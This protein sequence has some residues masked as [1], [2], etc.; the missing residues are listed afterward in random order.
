MIFS[1]KPITEH[2]VCVLD[3]SNSNQQ[4]IRNQLAAYKARWNESLATNLTIVT[5]FD[6]APIGAVVIAPGYIKPSLHHTIHQVTS[7]NQMTHYDLR[8]AIIS[9]LI[10]YEYT[11]NTDTALSWLDSLPTIF[12]ADFETSSK[13]DKEEKQ[14]IQSQI[15]K[16][17]PETDIYEITELQ[18][19]LES[20]GL[21]HPSL[22][23][24]THLVI[25]LSETESRVIIFKDE[26]MI[27]PI[28]NKLVETTN[29]QIWHNLSFD[30]KHILYRTAKFP[31]N[32]EDT[33]LL[34]WSYLNHANTF[35]AKVGLKQLAGNIYGDWAVSAD[36]FASENK[37]DES[38]IKYAAIDGMATWYVWNEFSTIEDINNIPII[39]QL[40]PVPDLTDPTKEQTPRFFYENVMKPS[41]PDMV[42][43]MLQGINI[44][45][46]EVE[47]LRNTVDD[48]LQQVKTTLSAN[49]IIQEFQAKRFAKAKQARLEESAYQMKPYEFFIDVF[50]INDLTHRSYLMEHLISSRLNLNLAEYPLESLPN[51]KTKWSVQSIKKFTKSQTNEQ[52]KTILDKILAKDVNPNSSN[53]IATMHKLAQDKYAVFSKEIAD[54]I[55]S[56]TPDSLPKSKYKHEFNPN[57]STQ[58][59]GL[60]AMLDIESEETTKSGN[61]SWNRAQ[62]ER[63]NKETE[64]EHIKEITQML[65]DFSFSAII[66]NN[67]IRAFDRFVID[68]VLYGNVKLA[69]AKS[70]RLTSSNPNLLNLPSSR[71]LYAKP[72]KKCLVAPEGFLIAGSDY[73]ALEEVVGANI[74]K[75]K[76]KVKILGGGY[77]SHCFHTLYYWRE[78][79]EKY[80][81]PSDDSLEFN[82][83][84]KKKTKDIPELDKLRSNSKPVSFGLGYGCMPPKVAKQI[85]GTLEEGQTIYNRYHYELYPDITEFRENHVLK[86]A[87]ET[88]KVYLGLG[89]SIKTDNPDADIRTL[90]NARM[91]FWSLLTLLT[92][93]QMNR[94]IREC[95]KVADIQVI[96]TIYDSIY[97]NVR[98]NPETIKWLNDNLIPIMVQPFLEDQPVP[99]KANLDIG[100]SFAHMVELPNNASIEEIE[101]A[102][103]KLKEY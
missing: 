13:F 50:N 46:D 27:L 91:Q 54:K 34:A 21:S 12:T 26:S 19:Q 53:C 31:K 89:L 94:L 72:L 36:N 55:A 79:V 9:N 82:T 83:L 99:N 25:G 78:E 16:L 52:L 47:N 57:S 75:D 22:T 30:A 68:S 39:Q 15:D 38:L 81:G 17:D 71:S 32:Y 100:D 90:F 85:K 42:Q 74:T 64:N 77:D 3:Q 40:L 84:F 102:L 6:D 49:P 67:F 43:M 93:T 80:L 23:E 33:Q 2:L 28:L 60:F 98:N 35:R 88:G 51:G 4:H 61:P 11:D 37:Y 63:V 66:R 96:A 24:L 65:I 97:F 86:P 1:F 18:Q 14:F 69:G 48:V 101:E 5:S 70:Y 59:V 44:N 10:H 95:G 58:K 62:V 20:S 56:I 92:I 29:K 41:I 8:A 73:S 103:I 76:N 45:L 87:K 7:I